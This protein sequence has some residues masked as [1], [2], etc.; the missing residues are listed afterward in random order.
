MSEDNKSHIWNDLRSFSNIIFWGA[1][2]QGYS[3]NLI[4]LGWL[5]VPACSYTPFSGFRPFKYKLCVICSC[6]N[7]N[8]PKG[9]C[10]NQY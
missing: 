9:F 2:V 1:L 3:L 8:M 5:A 6:R 7:R 10:I 4:L